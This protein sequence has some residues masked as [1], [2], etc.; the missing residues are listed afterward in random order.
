[1]KK[2]FYLLS[3]AALA[4]LAGCNKDE[5]TEITSGS[6]GSSE[7]N[8]ANESFDRTINVTFGSGTATVSG[9][10]SDFNV[11][12]SG[13]GVTIVNNSDEKVIYQLSGSTSNGY[14]KIY[15]LKKQAIYLNSVS[16]TNP[17]GAAINIQ[18]SKD[19]LS[20]AK[21]TYVVLG[22]SA[23]LTDGS[24][25]STTSGED[26]KG[27]FFSE[28][29]LVF[30]GS[31]SLSVTA[32]GRGGIVS[33]DYIN[34]QDGTITVNMT[35]S[36]SVSSGDTI[37]P[38]CMRGKEDFIVS[39]GT[40]NLTSTG[41]GGKGISGDG[42]A[43]FQGGTVKITVSGSNYG[44]SGGSNPPGHKASDNSVAAK[45]IKFDGN[46]VFSGSTVTVSCT[47]HEGIESKAALTVS[48]GSV[49]SY[50]AGDD[51]I[52]SSSDMTI[53]GG[54]VGAY[55]TSND[56]LDA[57]G[58]LYIKGG[59]VY[60]VSSAGNP[61]V[62]IDANTE[63]G[64]QLYVQGGTLF[65]VGGLESGASLSQSCYQATSVSANTWYGLTVGST[66]YAIKTPA[67]VGSSIVVSG[68]STPTLKSGV[69]VSGG[70]SYLNGYLPTGGSVSGGSS[71]SLSS[72]SGGN[73]NG[74][75]DDH[76]GG[77]DPHHK[78]LFTF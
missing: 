74:G 6:G 20:K 31:G 53:S 77:N 19:S 62:A 76:G 34:V 40:L 75:G 46:I 11:S 59:V 52:N 33:D 23:S 36:V 50:S 15:S 73:G 25:Y 8:I 3:I 4:V 78:S 18:G 7:D 21:R 22:G 26:M 51:A 72:Y 56:A 1:M 44:S 48:G 16:I 60:A 28:G 13:N 71:V 42:T 69:S 2:V 47:N 66:T 49:Y 27:A 65:A 38:A 32:K 10:S 35:S 68:S 43:Y 24:S 45:G 61:E 55:S 58:N 12:I 14:L 30:S 39:G 67:S 64:K 17:S 41:T 57:N 70:T 29:V 37:K 63:G 5:I 9:Q 54:Y